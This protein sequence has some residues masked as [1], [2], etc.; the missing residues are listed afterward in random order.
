VNVRFARAAERDL[1]EIGDWIS[2]DDPRAAARFV[3]QLVAIA[4]QIATM[5]NAFASATNDPG[6]Q[7]RKQSFR[8]YM[9][10]YRVGRTTVTIIRVLRHSHDQ[11]TEL[12]S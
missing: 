8:R 11:A 5:T 7:L 1:E 4:Q 10:F 3:T 6:G 12:T 2:R 9:I